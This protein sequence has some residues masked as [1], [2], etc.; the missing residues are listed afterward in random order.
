MQALLGVYSLGLVPGLALGGPASDRLGRRRLALPFSAV[1]AL[2]TLV[3][4]AGGTWPPLLYAG[5][6]LAGI[7]TGTVLAAGTAWVKELSPVEGP[8]LTALAV[9]AGFGVGPFCAAMVA[10]WAPRPLV[11]AYLPHLLL[12]AVAV[13]L[14]CRVPETLDPGTRPVGRLKLT[15]LRHPAFVR[16]LVPLGIWVFTAATTV[17]ALLPDRLHVAHWPTLYAGTLCLA[18]LGTGMAVQPVARRLRPRVT[19]RAGL[20]LVVAGFLLAALTVAAAEPALAYATA[21]PM[22]AGYGMCLVYGLGE[23]A[24]TAAPSELAGLTAAFYAV[25]YLGMFGPLVFTLLGSAV[26]TPA[27]L[28]AAAALAACSLAAVLRWS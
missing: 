5:R 22:G 11:T 14:A 8:R 23:V 7:V 24:R 9:S 1:S 17:F 13:P 10:Q 20:A 15:G 21:V 25:T 3:L 6:F 16:V 2:V 4:V 27:L 26:P 28:L 19:A 18:T 12:M